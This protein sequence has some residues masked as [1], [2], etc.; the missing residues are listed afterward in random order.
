MV[1]TTTGW[2]RGWIRTIFRSFLGSISDHQGVDSAW[3]QPQQGGLEGGLEPFLG[4][5]SDHQGVDSAW[6]QPQQG[7][8]EGGLE[9]FL[10]HFW[11]QFLI[12]K[13]LILHGIS[14]TTGWIRGWIRTN[15]WIIFGINF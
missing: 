15:F 2:I 5:I 12:I 11:D 9:P 6:Y 8:L 13:V 10:D 14:T 4:S 1:S 3:Y 7:G